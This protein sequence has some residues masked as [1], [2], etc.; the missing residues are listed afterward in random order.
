L[1]HDHPE[2]DE[3]RIETIQPAGVESPLFCVVRTGAMLALR[4]FAAAL[5]VGRPVY[6][7]SMPSMYSTRRAA[8][9][10]QDLAGEAVAAVR[11]QRPHGPYCLFGHSMGGLVAYEMACQLAGAGEPI[12]LVVLAD[13]PNPRLVRQQFR[14]RF[15]PRR[16]VALLVRRGPLTVLR[17]FPWPVGSWVRRREYLPGTHVSRDQ[18]AALRRELRYQPGSFDGPVAIVKSDLRSWPDWLGWD[19]PTTSE[20]QQHSV[21][22]SHDSMLGEPHVHAVAATLAGCLEHG[23]DR[24]VR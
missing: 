10:I 6:G 4:H 1:R 22:G 14:R 24:R 2:A 21:P 7:I 23:P 11:E 3:L 13:T 18:A 17:S 19:P 16:M 8:G 12:E 9:D 15:R 5:G 20:W